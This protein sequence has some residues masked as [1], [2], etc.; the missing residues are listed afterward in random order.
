MIID[1]SMRFKSRNFAWI[2]FID[3]QFFIFFFRD[4]KLIH[5]L[6]DLIYSQAQML[7]KTWI[8]YY[9]EKSRFLFAQKE[10]TFVQD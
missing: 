1:N 7:E 9:P 5:L 10:I 4:V 8:S 3:F 6:K 2:Q